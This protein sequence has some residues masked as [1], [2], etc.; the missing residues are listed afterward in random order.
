M[1]LRTTFHVSCALALS[2]LITSSIAQQLSI[3][4]PG[5]DAAV[6]SALQK[7]TGPLSEQDLLGLTALGA[8][9]R[10]I[11]NLQGLEA[12]HNLTFLNLRSNSLA[13]LFFPSGL[14]KLSSLDLGFNPLTNCVFPDGLTNLIGLVIENAQLTNLALPATMTNLFD[15]V[16]FDNR[17]T[18]LRLP[19][20]SSQMDFL[21]L[22]GNEL[23]SLTFPEGLTRLTELELYANQL[24]SLT[25][26]ADMTNL[27]GLALF[28]NQL[29]N[30]SLPAGLKTLVAL[31]LDGNRFT[32]F[33]LPASLTRLNLLNLHGNQLTNVTLPE[34]LTNLSFLYLDDNQLTRLSLPLGLTKLSFLKLNGNQFTELSL[35]P[36]LTN[37][38]AIFLQNNQ[39]T[40]LSLAPG[41]NH[42]V[43]LD[44][45]TNDLT[46]LTLPPDM[47]DLT[48]LLLDGNPLT[49][50]V[51][52]E[53]LAANQL[54]G[55]VADLQAQGVQVFTYPLSVQLINAGQP[56][57]TFQFEL[58][59]PPG[60][61]AILASTN[62]TS[63]SVLDAVNNPFGSVVFNDATSQSVPRRFYRAQP[64]PTPPANMVLVAPNTFEL[65]S[66][67]NEVGHQPDE[68][69]QTRVTLS[70]AFWISK[71]LVTQGD[72][73]AVTGSN[74][75]QFPGDLSRPVESVSWF[76]ASNYCARL[77]A[78][79][80]AAGRIPSHSHYRLST[81]AEWEC[82]ARAGTT[83]RFNYGED[84]NV[85]SLTNHA[86]YGA[87]SGLT[88][89]PV[90]QKEPNAWGLYDMAGNVWEW[91]QDWYGPYPGGSVTDPQGPPSNQIGFKVVRGGA[92]E[93]FELDCRSARRSIEGA[94]PFISDFI[95]GFR[96]VLVL[97][98]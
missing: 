28:F 34:G 98:P 64:V 6:R 45:R 8:N 84:P 94:S 31:D 61:Y 86:W 89:R 69:P 97:D 23:G 92:W 68:S 11:T 52:P 35:P 16:L 37:L 88:T 59:G 21:D 63:W 62:L 43:Q 36:G 73:L 49:T 39:L 87:N 80:L 24:T 76:D 75:S 81:E 5:L 33:D 3:P 77:T 90:G 72:Y 29:T 58:T 50:L 53:P 32:S 25:L 48:T 54:S 67:T 42:L 46:S 70:R 19:A 18:S 15:L 79:D 20:G 17:L 60:V 41:L 57:V 22:S 30:L 74:P 71:F 91:C 1:N 66:P 83:T 56:L 9:S 7:P 47:T 4:D 96:V 13:N 55:T 65:G 12:A 95:I 93:S 10:S 2:G 27:V 44:L 51:L 38:G 14:E 40:N 26:P 78:Q 82:A 85:T